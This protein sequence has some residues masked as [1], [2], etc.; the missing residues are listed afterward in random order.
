MY[1]YFYI[2][3][4]SFICKYVNHKRMKNS[5]L[6]STDFPEPD[7]PRTAYVFP[8]RTF[9]LKSERTCFSPKDLFKFLI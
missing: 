3:E 2:Y 5:R 8:F 4:Y 9:K 7:F 6:M 1:I